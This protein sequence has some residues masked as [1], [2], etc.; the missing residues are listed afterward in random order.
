M[1]ACLILSLF[2]MLARG[3]GIEESEGEARRRHPFFPLRAGRVVGGFDQTA[4]QGS[5]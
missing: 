4:S 2:I 3:R 5:R 1:R